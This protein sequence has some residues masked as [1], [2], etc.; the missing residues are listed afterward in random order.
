[1]RQAFGNKIITIASQADMPKAQDED[2]KGLFQYIDMF[3]LMNYDYTVSDLEDSPI[4]APN[5]NLYPAPASTGI[6]ND[7][8]SVTINGYL[9]A[10]IPP[11]K[12]AVGVAFYGHAWYV[13]GL[14]SQSDWCQFG[15]KATKQGQCCGDFAQTMGAKYG[16]YSQLCGTYMY[17][18]V[19]AAGFET[20]FNSD[21]SSNIGYA[22]NPKDGY[23]A[24]GVWIS[25]QDTETVSAIVNFAKSKNLGGAFAFDISMDSMSGSQFTYKLTKEIAQLEG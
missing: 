5:E 18:E 9:A 4:T 12:M 21:T 14:S 15:L 1:M 13:P 19:E 11:A 20:C 17:S 25:Y 16:K 8:V 2:I 6:W 24:K 10:G 7:S 3:N 22:I 23:T